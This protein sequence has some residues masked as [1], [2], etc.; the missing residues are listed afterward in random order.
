MDI[1]IQNLAAPPFV[2]NAIGI[3]SAYTQE[4]WPTGSSIVSK[5]PAP[6]A[7]TPRSAAVASIEATN[8]GS[9]IPSDQSTLPKTMS[10]QFYDTQITTV[11]YQI[12]FTKRDK[13][14]LLDSG[15][16]IVTSA[17]AGSGFA[18]WQIALFMQR[19]NKESN[20]LVDT[21]GIPKPADWTD[22]EAIEL[23]V[24]VFP[25]LTNQKSPDHPI[26][27]VIGLKPENLK[28]L[29]VDHQIISTL[30]RKPP[31]YDADQIDALRDIAAVIKKGR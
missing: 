8:Y 13:E 19:L 5:P 23:A 12:L 2:S 9:R 15:R 16:M 27:R 4:V 25:L 6:K 22:N 3:R 31:R 20:P 26:S 29:Q 1:A 14:A 10:T 18:S 30:D 28:Y 24:N 7:P 21:D 17:M 11:D